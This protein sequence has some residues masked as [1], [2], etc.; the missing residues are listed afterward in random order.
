[1]IRESPST[2]YIVREN[3]DYQPTI[4]RQSPARYVVE[5]PR[6]I[7]RESPSRYVVED[8]SRPN[9]IR[10]SE[11]VRRER[12]PSSERIRISPKSPRYVT[13]SVPTVV[14][15]SP[16]SYIN[17]TNKSPYKIYNNNNNNY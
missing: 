3:V 4:V 16:S 1:M 11:F 13:D 6:T 2:N 9:V 5:E 17:T 7:I 12:T 14:R 15:Q 10:E 8:S